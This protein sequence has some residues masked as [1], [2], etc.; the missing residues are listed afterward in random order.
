MVVFRSRNA[1][2]RSAAI[3]SAAIAAVLASSMVRADLQWDTVPTNGTVDGGSG[4]WDLLTPNWTADSGVTNTIWDS[5]GAIFGGA[6][7]GTVT[8]N[9]GGATL[10]ATSLTFNVTT[11]ASLY[12]LVSNTAADTLTLTGPGGPITVNQSLPSIRLL[13]AVSAS[14][15][16]ELRPSPSAA[17]TLLPAA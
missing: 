17:P 15:N 5:T 14:L 2:S 7:G 10:N 1:V 8:L 12:T 9:N 4:T 3:W 13:A 11:D 16:W 6:T